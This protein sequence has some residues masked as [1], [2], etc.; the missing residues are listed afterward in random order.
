MMPAP[1]RRYRF[2][3]FVMDVV[4]RRLRRGSTY[5]ALTP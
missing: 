3:P 2:G 5:V 1:A 4:E